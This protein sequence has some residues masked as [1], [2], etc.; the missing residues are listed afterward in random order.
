MGRPIKKTSIT[1]INTRLKT[2]G[3][4]GGTPAVLPVASLPTYCDVARFYYTE[5]K[6]QN[7]LKTITDAIIEKWVHA[8][9]QLPL[10]DYYGVRYKVKRFK[11]RLYKANANKATNKVLASLDGDKDKLFDISACAC[12]LPALDCQ[13]RNIPCTAKNCK[14]KQIYC[15]GKKEN[16]VKDQIEIYIML[17]HK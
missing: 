2:S 14:I 13:A 5:K 3:K 1:G 12:P 4:W 7:W 6:D 11:E 17:F 10:M 9:P 15:L 16:K 8:N